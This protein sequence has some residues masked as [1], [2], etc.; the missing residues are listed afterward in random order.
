[1][2]WIVLF[3]L[4]GVFLFAAVMYGRAKGI[5][6]MRKASELGGG[7]TRPAQLGG[8]H[9]RSAPGPKTVR[10]LALN[11]IVSHLG[12]D[13]MVEGKLVFLE[14]GDQWYEYMLV[15]GSEVR[16]LCVEDDDVLELSLYQVVRDLPLSS[17]PAETIEYQ[18]VRFVLQERGVASMRREGKTGSRT[19]Q[20]CTYWDYESAG[21]GDLLLSVERWGQSYE[22]SVGREVDEAA[23]DIL[24]G[25]LVI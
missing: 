14:D 23:L 10:S 13:F 11:D 18:G 19:A 5:E 17:D 6:S 7:P 22:V 8:R 9:G 21:G 4:G 2:I 15:D 16:W 25:E 12:Q 24:S 20:T 3:L 1:M